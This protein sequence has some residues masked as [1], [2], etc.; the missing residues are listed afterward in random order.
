MKE[1]FEFLLNKSQDYQKSGIVFKR[2]LDYVFSFLRHNNPF[3]NDC[4]L[5]ELMNKFLTRR[6]YIQVDSY[7]KKL[8]SCF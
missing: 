7:I 6:S 4:Y 5:D 2:F 8:I 1:K 3:S